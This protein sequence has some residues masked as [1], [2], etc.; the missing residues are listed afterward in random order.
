MMFELFMETGFP[1]PILG[2]SCTGALTADTV[3]PEHRLVIKSIRIE[4]PGFWE[5]FAS[6]N[7]LQ[8]IREYLNDRHKRKQDREF[9]EAKTYE[10]TCRMVHIRSLRHLQPDLDLRLHP[11][12]KGLPGRGK[13][14]FRVLLLITL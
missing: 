5:V 13:A 8:Q 6:L 12:K 2:G 10:E 7:P 1:Y 11:E 4:S 3:L 14:V 9:R